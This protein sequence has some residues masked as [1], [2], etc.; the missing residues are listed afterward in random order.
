VF[1]TSALVLALA[2]CSPSPS[3]VEA[4]DAADLDAFLNDA[5]EKCSSLGS[6]SFGNSS[7]TI[8]IEVFDECIAY[9]ANQTSPEFRSAVCALGRSG[10]YETPPSTIEVYMDGDTCRTDYE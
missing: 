4:V 10:G 5:R 1:R 3:S 9:Y 2:A 8:P 6:W 7:T